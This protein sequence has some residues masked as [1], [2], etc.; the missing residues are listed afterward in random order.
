VNIRCCEILSSP[1]LY[2]TAEEVNT[3]METFTGDWVMTVK[4]L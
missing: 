3:H 1:G 2:I 4:E